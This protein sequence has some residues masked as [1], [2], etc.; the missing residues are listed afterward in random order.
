MPSSV[1]S[2]PGRAEAA[3]HT[4]SV[5]RGG[6]VVWRWAL[7]WAARVRRPPASGARASPAR[8]GSMCTGVAAWKKATLLR[9]G[10]PRR[11]SLFHELAEDVL[12]GLG[13]ARVDVGLGGPAAAGGEALGVDKGAKVDGVG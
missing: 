6:G 9:G 1:A 12:A 4:G 8:G 3:L 7:G 13:V 10:V 2:H 11:A 5:R